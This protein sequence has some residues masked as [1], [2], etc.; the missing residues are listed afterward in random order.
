MIDTSELI[1]QYTDS[2]SGMTPVQTP[3][4]W[5]VASGTYGYYTQGQPVL[6][7]D[8]YSANLAQAQQNI[9]REAKQRMEQAGLTGTRWSTPAQRQIADVSGQYMTGLQSNYANMY[10]N[11]MESAADRAM[12]AASGLTGLGQQYFQAPMDWAQQAYGLGSAQQ[13]TAQTALDRLYNYF[14][15]QTPES[16]PWLTQASNYASILGNYVPTQYQPSGASQALG[17]ISSILPLLALFL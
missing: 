11:A 5:D 4:E 13:S 12:Q 2:G 8:W 10:Q 6:N 3:P 15:G 16:S 14:Q 9:E 1:K 7:Q 17:G